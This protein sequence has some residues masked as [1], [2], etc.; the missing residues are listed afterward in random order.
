[1]LVDLMHLAGVGKPRRFANFKTA[2][3]L[4]MESRSLLA[5]RSVNM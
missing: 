2:R 5:A 1:M 3:K 4:W